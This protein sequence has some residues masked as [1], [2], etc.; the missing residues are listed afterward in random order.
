MWCQA[1]CS[2]GTSSHARIDRPQGVFGANAQSIADAFAAPDV[3][4]RPEAVLVV[5]VSVATL[6]VSCRCL[7]NVVRSIVCRSI[8]CVF[9]L[10]AVFFV[11]GS[12]VL[13][14]SFIM[15][16]SLFSSYVTKVRDMCSLHLLI[17]SLMALWYVQSSSV[18]NTISYPPI[19]DVC[20]LFLCSRKRRVTTQITE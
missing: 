4:R 2:D 6:L 13:F 10:G 14:F 15:C 7:D 3:L 11:L 16:A 9:V 5:K 17:Q 1:D 20:D 18:L 8:V 19:L 12:T